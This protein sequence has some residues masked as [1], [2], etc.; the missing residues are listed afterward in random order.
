M[1]HRVRALTN[2]TAFNNQ[3]TAL[4]WRGTDCITSPI[5]SLIIGSLAFCKF[6]LH[7]EA[8]EEPPSRLSSHPHMNLKRDTHID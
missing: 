6:M 3:W 4:N 2:R 8:Y 1:P 7:R 5:L